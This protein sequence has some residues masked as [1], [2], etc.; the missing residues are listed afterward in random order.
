MQAGERVLPLR[1]GRETGQ[2][3]P[4]HAPCSHCPRVSR[5]PRDSSDVSAASRPR[6]LKN[7]A[8]RQQVAALKK[9]RP[10]PPLDDADRAFWVALRQS[11]PGWARGL[12]INAATVARWNRERFR[13]YWAKI[14]QRRY[15][16]RPRV[17]GEIRRLIRGWLRM[18]G[19]HRVSTR[20]SRSSVSSCPR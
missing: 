11:W 12:V 13:R 8:L 15:P 18:A 19:A 7:L 14:S 3:P 5:R 10:R 1:S 4:R 20:S 17:D 16:G 2:T 9:E 6:D